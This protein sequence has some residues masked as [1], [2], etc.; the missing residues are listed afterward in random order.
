MTRAP[1]QAVT[2]L[3]TVGVSKTYGRTRVLSDVSFDVRSGEVHALLG[4]NGSG[5]STLIKALAGVLS[6]DFGGRIDA[7]GNAAPATRWSPHHARAAHLRFVHQDL[8]LFPGLSLVDNLALGS[9]FV[10]TRWG[11]VRWAASR[12]RACTLLQRYGIDAGP[13][14]I[15]D[16]LS[17]AERAMLAI[18]RALQDVGDEES[19]V[20][21]LD[22]PTGA[23]PADEAQALHCCADSPP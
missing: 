1:G 17:L 9:G 5:K 4:G 11:R 12:E 14:A 20:V 19:A 7:G 22:E 13:D 16:E 15:V 3:R 6:F 2:L 21:M 18:A 8:G 23:L 10:R